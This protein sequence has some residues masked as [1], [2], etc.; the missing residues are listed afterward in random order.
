MKT[1]V[2]TDTGVIVKVND[3]VAT[4][5]NHRGVMKVLPKDEQSVAIM[6]FHK[7]SVDVNFSEL[8]GVSFIDID[9]ATLGPGR[10]IYTATGK[11]VAVGD[12]VQCK[13]HGEGRLIV[14]PVLHTADSAVHF[15]WT[16][17]RIPMDEL[18]GTE[19]VLDA[20]EVVSEQDMHFFEQVT[21]LTQTAKSY[22]ED[23]EGYANQIVNAALK[24]KAQALFD[25]V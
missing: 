19:W 4:T 11:E 13:E 3:V 23:A 7:A 17:I 22:L 12:K 8:A 24:A 20:P 21:S 1:L 14:L 2:Y 18:L 15:G 6:D 10:L 5:G 9:P 16:T 25:N